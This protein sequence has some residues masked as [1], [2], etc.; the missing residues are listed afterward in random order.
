MEEQTTTQSETTKDFADARIEVYHGDGK[1]T[2]KIEQPRYTDIARAL[3]N[4]ATSFEDLEGRPFDEGYQHPDDWIFC[5]TCGRQIEK[6]DQ[7]RQ[8]CNDCFEESDFE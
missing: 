4:L 1:S 6:S 3:R 8:F 2:V 7:S 5:Q